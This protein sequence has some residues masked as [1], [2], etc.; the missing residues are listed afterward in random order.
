MK[1]PRSTVDIAVIIL[2]ATVGLTL[3]ALTLGLILAKIINPAID[4]SHLATQ[5]GNMMQ[6]ILG[7][8]VGFIGGRAVGKSE[9]K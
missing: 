7:A 4:T 8:L 5:I 3:L 6:T 1:I 2:T 9:A